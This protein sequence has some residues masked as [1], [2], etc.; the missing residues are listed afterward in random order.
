MKYDDASWHYDSTPEFEDDE[1]WAVAAAHI[2]VYLKWC[3]LQGWAGELHTE[4]EAD[5]NMVEQVISGNMTG[6]EFLIQQCDCQFTNEELND[7]GNAF[8]S[9]YFADHYPEDLESVAREQILS[10]P[11][12]EYDFDALREIFDRQYGEWLA[13]NPLVA[14]PR[15]SPAE[16]SPSP[17]ETQSTSDHPTFNEAQ[18][19]NAQKDKPWWKVW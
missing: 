1:R 6:A 11:E 16:V 18:T 8:T 15:V 5:Q 19:E 3:L 17:A 2:G 13:E 7:E 10:A 14:P 12:S 4:D 9:Y